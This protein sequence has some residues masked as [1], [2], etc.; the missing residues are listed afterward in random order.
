M[1][2][3]VL[4]AG[5]N[6][7]SSA[8]HVRWNRKWRRKTAQYTHMLRRDPELAEENF[9]AVDKCDDWDPADKLAAMRRWTRSK[10][11]RP[12]SEVNSKLTSFGGNTLAGVHLM[13]HVRD[14]IAQP[15]L[16]LKDSMRQFYV[17]AEGIFR[18]NPDYRWYKE[19]TDGLQSCHREE[20]LHEFEQFC[21][22]RHLLNSGGRLYW[23]E[24]ASEFEPNVYWNSRDFMLYTRREPRVTR[25]R[26]GRPLT[27]RELKKFRRF[28][29]PIRHW[30]LRC[31]EALRSGSELPRYPYWSW[32]QLWRLNR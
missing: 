28:P 23:L 12:W 22:K 11:G 17:D 19:E 29:E 1:S 14:W 2:R 3:T 24:P 21:N 16:P 18:E 26:Q 8:R 10:V 7:K 5:N 15:G 6:Y 30:A 13:G 20:L 27:E 4:E 25:Y 31:S 32:R 9:Y